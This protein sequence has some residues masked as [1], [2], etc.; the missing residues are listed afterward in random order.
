MNALSAAWERYE[1]PTW[2][3]AA[4]VYGG[5]SVLLLA[6]AALPW[7]AILLIG[8][9][10]IAWHGS[11]QH[12]TIHGLRRVPRFV[13]SLL[14]APP[15]GVFFPYAVYRRS[16]MRHHRA[17]TLTIPIVDPESFYHP[18][19]AWQRYPPLVRAAYRVNQT[20]IGRLLVGPALQI[21]SLAAGGVRA[22]RRGDAAAFRDAGAHA[23]M[24]GALLVVVADV[25]RMPWWQYLV[26]I[27][28]PGAAL[29]MLRSFFEHRW[30]DDQAHR[31]ATVENRFPFGLLFL[32]NNYH[33]VHHDDPTLPW[34]QIPAVWNARRTELL[35]RTGD[36]YVNGYGAIARRWL[37]RP[38]GDPV[39]TAIPDR[40]VASAN[41]I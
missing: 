18:I 15:L 4:A 9:P 25:A 10:L 14:A 32:N 28:Y 20:L 11:L 40:T 6:H 37:V 38:L 12:E 27:A 30:A 36:F 29:G 5:W 16:H 3:I 8:A 17:D 22:L 41:R 31:T 19:E 1:G 21:G 26:L 33:A 39:F 24:L 34:Y 23:L 2:C 35:A 7:W 13:R